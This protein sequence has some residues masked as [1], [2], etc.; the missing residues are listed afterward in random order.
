MS[1]TGMMLNLEED[2][3]SI[4]VLGEIEVKLT[5]DKQGHLRIPILKRRV[6]EELL[7][8][9]WKGK[10][11]NEIKGAIMKL[12]TVWTGEWRQDMEVN[13]RSTVE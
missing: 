9:G 7:L 5:E 3:V 2:K 4:G 8:E 12:L 1:N 10:S 6:E 13:R 11:Q